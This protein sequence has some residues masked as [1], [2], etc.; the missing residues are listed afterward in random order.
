MSESEQIQE[1][2]RWLKYAEEDLIA[3]E[4]MAGQ[5]DIAPRHACWLAQQSAEKAIKAA[6]VFLQIKFP[7]NHDL[8]A[9]RNQIPDGWTIKTEYPDLASLSE[10]AVEA[11]YPGDWPEALERDALA[12]TKQARGILSSI[13]ADLSIRKFK[14]K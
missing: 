7:K 2:R 5:D 13:E 14:F 1:T 12:A 4:R 6:L 9:L 10:W 8:D 11:R 3:A